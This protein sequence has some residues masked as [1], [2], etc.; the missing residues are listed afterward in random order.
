M[1]FKKK[2]FVALVSSLLFACNNVDPNAHECE[3]ATWSGF[4]TSAIS[5]TFDDNCPN[6]YSIA[7]PLF[8]KYGFK[9]TFFPDV[10]KIDNWQTLSQCAENGHEIGSHT[11]NHLALSGLSNDELLEEVRGSKDVIDENVDYGNCITI[12]YPYCDMPDTN[13]VA[14]SY[15]AARICDNRIEPATPSRYYAI[16]SFGVGSESNDYKTGSSIIDLFKRTKAESGWCV[17]LIHEIDNGPGYSPLA[18]ASLDST[19]CFANAN[20]D[21]F[22]VATFGEV[23]KYTKERDN[24]TIALLYQDEET[25]GIMISNELDYVYDVP[26][27]I[28]R[29]LPSGWT[30]ATVEQNHELCVS[31]IKDGFVY[32]DIDPNKGE[33][34]IRKD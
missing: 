13:V 3:I 6:Q 30:N 31:C 16:S 7:L 8:D 28:R 15:I 5:Y 11:L 12:A 33:V 27:S 26:L 14:K 21:D 24:S 32:F 34:L 25:I 1:M 10:D 9:A 2:L 22:W 19:L 20:P 18:S 29:P 17:L 23:V 4:A